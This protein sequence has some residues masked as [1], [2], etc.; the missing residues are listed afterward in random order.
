[1][2]EKTVP[3]RFKKH[4]TYYQINKNVIDEAMAEVYPNTRKIGRRRKKM[5]GSNKKRASQKESKT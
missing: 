5:V 4:L 3:K 2:S 1:M